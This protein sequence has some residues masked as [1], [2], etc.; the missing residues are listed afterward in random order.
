MRAVVI[1]SLILSSFFSNIAISQI[2]IYSEGAI[3]NWNDIFFK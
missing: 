1:L 2:T 3:E